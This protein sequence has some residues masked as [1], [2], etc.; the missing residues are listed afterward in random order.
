MQDVDDIFLLD[1]FTEVYVWVGD[2]ANDSEKK[3]ASGT[4]NSATTFAPF[5]TNNDH[6]TK[7]GSG[8]T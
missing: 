4:K 2:G 5:D 3:M 6:F 1:C 7:T 8:Q